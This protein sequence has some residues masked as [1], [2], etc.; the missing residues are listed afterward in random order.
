M[1]NGEKKENSE[2]KEA[3][4][5]SDYSSDENLDQLN[6][7]LPNRHSKRTHEYTDLVGEHITERDECSEMT[8]MNPEVDML[9]MI[10]SIGKKNKDRARL[11]KSLTKFNG[12]GRP[13][14]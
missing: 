3:M 12:G 4:E 14:S 8:E 6:A 13:S 2:G 5:S 1:F 7:L 10:N 9:D 11:K